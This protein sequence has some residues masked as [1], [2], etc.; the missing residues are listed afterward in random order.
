MASKIQNLPAFKNPPVV[1]VVAGVQ[2]DR[3]AHLR[4]FDFHEIWT[5]FGQ[6]KFSKYTEMPPL[7]PLPNHEDGRNIVRLEWSA[8]PEVPRFWFETVQGDELI[9]IQRDRFIYNWR[10]ESEAPESAYPRYK[11]VSDGFFRNYDAFKTVL[12]KKKMPFLKPQVQE[13]AYVNIIEMPPEGL[14]AMNKIFKAEF[15]IGS[16]SL[17]PNPAHA[18]S[19]WQ[20]KIEA[21]KSLMKITI[22]PVQS[23]QTGKMLIKLDINVTGPSQIAS[24]ETESNDMKKWFDEARHWIVKSF[25]DI[26]TQEM[27][28]VWNRTS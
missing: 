7:D 8:L 4:V 11:S 28:K 15:S 19:E 13:L 27:H 2:F 20:F 25:A 9:Q 14:S 18:T 24:K 16:S 21:I 1:E 22:A 12:E 23:V 26:T 3:P 17:L 10:R 6:S 5:A